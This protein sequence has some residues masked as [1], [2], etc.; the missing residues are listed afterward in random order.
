MQRSNKSSQILLDFLLKNAEFKPRTL[1][2]ND[3]L[4]RV[5][6]VSCSLYVVKVGFCGFILTT[7][8][9]IS[10]CNFSSQMPSC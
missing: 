8:A 6:E 9:G 5:G 2:R 10:R 3:E 1:A 4:V 7:L